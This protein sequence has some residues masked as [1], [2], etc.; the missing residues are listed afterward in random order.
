ML[1]V[2]VFS[3]N[4]LIYGKQEILASSTIIK[5]QKGY[6]SKPR[7]IVQVISAPTEYPILIPLWNIPPSHKGYIVPPHYVREYPFV[8]INVLN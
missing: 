6:F 2:K 8:E 1:T 4:L 3:T 5:K 7:Q